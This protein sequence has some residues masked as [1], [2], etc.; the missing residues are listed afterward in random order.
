MTSFQ[1][2]I[3]AIV[4]MVIDHVGAFFFPDTMLLRI[5]GRLSFPLFSFLIANGAHYTGNI[6]RYIDRML[7]FAL[8]SQIPYQL[9]KNLDGNSDISLNILFTFTLAL[10]AIN[11]LR[12][13]KSMAISFV[14]IVLTS[15]SA[16]VLNTSYGVFGILLT[17]SF[18]LLFKNT[19]LFVLSF[20]ILSLGESIAPAISGSILAV[21]RID[22]GPLFSLFSLVF[23]L[24]Y[25]H[26]EGPKAK[27]LFYIFYPLQYLVIY[28]IKF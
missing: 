23:I 11:I 17:I 16:F 7:V 24:L 20:F 2:K 3:I 15:I 14:V 19:R 13:A 10:I 12:S 21:S 4:T 27:Y 5:I 26:K 18:Y 25:N 9:V 8:I 28:L 6:S 22:L 1:I